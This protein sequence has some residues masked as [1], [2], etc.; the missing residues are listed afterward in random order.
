MSTCLDIYI[1]GSSISMNDD[2]LVVEGLKKYF[3]IKKGFFSKTTNYV[4]AVDGVD[5]V[6]KRGQTLGLVGES[7]C[8]KSTTGRTILN[9]LSPTEGKVVFDGKVLF[10]V[11][12]NIYL[13]KSEMLSL[14][15][16]IQIIFQDP[17]ACLDPRMNVEKIVSEGI[18]KHKTVKEKEIKEKVEELLELCGL[19]RDQLSKYPHQFSGGQRQRI[20]IARALSLDPKFIVCDEPTAALDVSIQSQILNLMIELRHKFQ[21]SYL[22]ISHDLSVVRNFCDEICVMYLGTIVEKAKSEELF[23]NT[24]HPYSKALLSAV[25]SF[26]PEKRVKRQLLEGDIPSPANPPIGCRFNTR[27]PY[28]KSICKEIRPELK[29]MGSEH[30]VACH[31][32]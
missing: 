14:R 28:A 23:K 20:G 22:F 3:P 9:L 21:L 7:G 2:I 8:G 32:V 13:N 4:K 27:C 25:P 12:N 29:N 11:K 16:D 5:F 30:L 19:G 31:L 10:D 18:R 17:Y 26:D 15:K 1:G 24:L 6:L